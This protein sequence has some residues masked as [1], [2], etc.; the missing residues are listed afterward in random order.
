MRLGIDVTCRDCGADVNLVNPGRTDGVESK[1][2][3]GCV[4]C[5]LEWLLTTHL[6]PVH[7][8]L[9]RAG[10]RTRSSEV[11]TALADEAR[12]L[13]VAGSHIKAA[14][15]TVGIDRETYRRHARLRAVPQS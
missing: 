3:L 8:P 15:R 11:V 10:T 12:Q 1:A 7:D 4:D 5:G 13:V 6:E 9:T 14:C 2:V